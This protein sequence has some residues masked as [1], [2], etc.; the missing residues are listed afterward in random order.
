MSS[1]YLE[2][3]PGTSRDFLKGN[4]ARLPVFV[5]SADFLVFSRT[6]S[7][8]HGVGAVA[9]RPSFVPRGRRA[10]RRDRL[11]ALVSPASVLA[12]PLFNPTGGYASYVVPAAFVLILQQTLLIGAAMLS[13]VAF[14]SGGRTAQLARGSSI[15]VL[16]HGLAHLVVYIPALLLFLVLLPRFYGF[17]TLGKLPDLSSSP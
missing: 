5:D 14:E 16:A 11:L 1:E 10:A 4:P 8:S 17:S 2:I 12:V 9:L 7:G 15:A 3:P 13:G 6:L